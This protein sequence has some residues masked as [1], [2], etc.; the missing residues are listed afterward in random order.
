CIQNISFIKIH[1]SR[2][3]Y[4]YWSDS[5]FP[6][7]QGTGGTILLP[8]RINAATGPVP[9]PDHPMLSYYDFGIYDSY[10]PFQCATRSPWNRIR[11]VAR[12]NQ[13]KFEMLGKEYFTGDEMKF[14]NS[15][16]ESATYKWVF[17]PGSTDSVNTQKIPVGISYSTTGQKRVKFYAYSP[18]GCVD[19]SN[20]S[21]EVLSNTPP[22]STQ[23]ICNK[24][25][26]TSRNF[27]N[28]RDIVEDQ[29]GNYYLTGSRI[30]FGPSFYPAGKEG[31]FLMK[32]NKN[33]QL[34]WKFE[35]GTEDS[36]FAFDGMDHIVMENVV[37]DKF[38]YTYVF[39]QAS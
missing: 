28:N 7:V 23:T 35:H 4:R 5:T 11:A 36:Y 2:V 34:V 30:L 24:D 10:V 1:N 22:P 38:G 17:E 15:S 12:M 14:R 20:I 21:I 19:S 29:Y 8:V 27:Y 26:V 32:F 3:D 6:T 31:W 9:I 33:K 37:A 18:E 39:G 13:A 16:I 25:S